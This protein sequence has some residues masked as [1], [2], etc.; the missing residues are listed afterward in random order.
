MSNNEAA[1]ISTG[2]VFRWVAGFIAFEL[3]GQVQGL[4]RGIAHDSDSS[5]GSG[6]PLV[7]CWNPLNVVGGC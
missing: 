2:K 1:T 3:R 6:E 4:G 5:S 7:A